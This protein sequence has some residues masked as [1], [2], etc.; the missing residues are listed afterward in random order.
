M[1]VPPSQSDWYIV[2]FDQPSYRG[3]PTNYKGPVSSL[4]R[5][6]QSVTIGKGVWE[7]CEGANFTG[8]CVTL[9]ESAPDLGTYNLRNRVASVRPAIPQPR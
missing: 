4:D 9:N 5:R 3:N 6:A 2:L 7:L 8:R 1:P